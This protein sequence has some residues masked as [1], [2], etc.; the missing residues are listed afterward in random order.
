MILSQ[1][2]IPKCEKRDKLDLIIS[3]TEA[4]WLSNALWL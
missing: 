4:E 3:Y 2:D 1:T